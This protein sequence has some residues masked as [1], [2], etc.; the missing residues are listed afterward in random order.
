MLPVTPTLPRPR[1]TALHAATVAYAKE[2]RNGP[3]KVNAADPGHTAKDLNGHHS[4]RRVEQAAARAVRPALPDDGPTG[5]FQNDGI[6]AWYSCPPEAALVSHATIGMAFGSG[7]AAASIR[8]QP[9][10][11]GLPPVMCGA[12]HRKIGRPVAN[13]PRSYRCR[14][15]TPASLVPKVA[16]L[17]RSDSSHRRA[18]TC[19]SAACGG[20][21]AA[22]G[23]PLISLCLSGP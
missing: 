3:I 18:A 2:L 21:F 12:T 10:A 16:P 5:T 17:R 20:T 7:A 22:A 11:R 19:M 23:A 4:Y 9:E 15:N 6:V 8:L 1:C 14:D 13:A